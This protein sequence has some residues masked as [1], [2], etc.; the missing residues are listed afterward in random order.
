MYSKAALYGRYKRKD[1]PDY[2]KYIERNTYFTINCARQYGKT[3]TLELLYHRLKDDY[4][5]LD[6]SFEASDDCFM[7]IFSLAQG[8]FNKIAEALRSDNA[9]DSLLEIWTEPVSETLP[10]DDLNRR[11]TEFCRRSD[12]EIILMADEADKAADSQLFLLLP[13]LQPGILESANF[14]LRIAA[15]CIIMLYIAVCKKQKEE[16]HG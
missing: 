10:M 5:V 8:F 9:A 4:I 3:T 15:L 7:S 6:L 14:Q 16:C 12:R 2:K 13:E 1:K 11:I